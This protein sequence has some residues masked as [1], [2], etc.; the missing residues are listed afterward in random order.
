MHAIVPILAYLACA[1]F[2]QRVQVGDEKDVQ[3]AESHA[4]SVDAM[5]SS[6]QTHVTDALNPLKVL[7]TLLLT[8]NLGTAFNIMTP[9]VH[10][11]TSDAASLRVSAAPVLRARSGIKVARPAKPF[12]IMVHGGLPFMNALNAR[13]RSV[14]ERYGEVRSC[15]VVAKDCK[16][17]GAAFV[18]MATE[19][20][21]QIA[22]EELHDT[23]FLGRRIDVVKGEF[24]PDHADGLTQEEW[25]A[26]RGYSVFLG[27]LPY[28]DALLDELWP[29]FE[30]YGQVVRINAPV[31]NQEGPKGYAFVSMM[32][33]DEGLAAMEG[34]QDYEMYGRSLKCS[35]A[36]PWKPKTRT[37]KS[38]SL[39][40][41]IFATKGRK[42]RNAVKQKLF[43]ET[44]RARGWTKY[45]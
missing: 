24:R 31:V 11:P 33:K 40:T 5:S 14:M 7:S 10:F 19:E 26:K 25:E 37:T 6:S 18:H 41:G 44:G 30:Q 12:E 22:I 9:R 2:G 28:T 1:G 38:G 36:L 8:L 35:F 32:N 27:N 45:R 42:A 17:Q 34:L 39:K 21:R 4:T 3:T 15:W 23:E 43:R 16:P 20:A 13:V 29:L